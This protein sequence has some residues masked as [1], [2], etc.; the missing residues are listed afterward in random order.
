IV[1]ANSATNAN[2]AAATN[3][4]A[5]LGATE[6][7]NSYGGN[8]TGASNPA[9]DHAGIVITASARDSAF[10]VPRSSYVRRGNDE[11]APPVSADCGN[12]INRS[13][14]GSLSDAVQPCSYSTVVCTGGTSLQTAGNSRG[15]NETEWNDLSSG[16]GSASSECSSYVTKP[17]WQSDTGCTKRSE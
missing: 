13:S 6:I 17:V 9:Y 16:N 15:Y 5:K 14:Y 10:G 11:T 4:A 12:G 7:S 3:E 8:E 1:E 2:L